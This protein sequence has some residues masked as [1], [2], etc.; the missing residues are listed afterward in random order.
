MRAGYITRENE[1]LPL[2][3]QAIEHLK[4][5]ASESNFIPLLDLPI[6]RNQQE[7][8][9][10]ISTGSTEVIHCPS[11]GYTARKETAQ[12][13]KPVE[14]EHVPPLPIEKVLTPDCH[15]IESLAKFLGVPEE[16]TAKALMFTSI[17]NNKFIFVVV[18]GDMQLSETKLKKLIGD[19]RTRNSGRNC[20]SG[21]RSGVCFTDWIERTH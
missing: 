2:G 20:Q 7:T 8:F 13:A 10:P 12:F 14:A 21:R 15:T 5:L 9:F 11:C 4:S 1:I 3:R 6:I 16:K 17:A 18:R 19:F